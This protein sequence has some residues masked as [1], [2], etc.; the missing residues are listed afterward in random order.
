MSGF[1]SPA[2]HNGRVL[3][4]GLGQKKKINKRRFSTKSSQ[5]WRIGMQREKNRVFSAARGRALQVVWFYLQAVYWL[6]PP[7]LF[8]TFSKN[9]WIIVSVHLLF[10]WV[11]HAFFL[12]IWKK[13]EFRKSHFYKRKLESRFSWFMYWIVSLADLVLRVI[14]L[15]GSANTPPP[16]V[17]GTPSITFHLEAFASLYLVY[18]TE[19]IQL[20]N[21]TEK[22]SLHC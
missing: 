1:L 11:I 19:K 13:Y 16:T 22:S 4:A 2:K 20:F 17:R 3:P 10:T 15:D 18:L 7:N 5:I 6:K 12:P 8:H 14:I 21:W 9:Y